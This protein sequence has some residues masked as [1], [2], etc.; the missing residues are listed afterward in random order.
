MYIY[1]FDLF[2]RLLKILSKKRKRS[3]LKIIPLAIV[4]GITDLLVVGL[5]SRV[6]AIVVQKKSSP[7][8]PFAYLFS[9]DPFTKLIILIFVF[10]SLHG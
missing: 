6:F 7:S 8:I 10:V 9:S 5:V 4:T 1:T 3:L 2:L